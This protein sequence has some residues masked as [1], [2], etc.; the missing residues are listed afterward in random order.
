MVVV[1]VRSD[2]IVRSDDASRVR[3]DA[4]VLRKEHALRE[5]LLP[6]QKEQQRG[7][8][9]ARPVFRSCGANGEERDSTDQ[10][11]AEEQRRGSACELTM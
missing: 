5:I 6:A 2:D 8:R 9:R 3:Q 4:D 1:L 7:R 11:E 10:V